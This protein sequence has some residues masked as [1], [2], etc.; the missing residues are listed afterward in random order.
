[1]A[2]KMRILR[3]ASDLHLELRS[4]LQHPKLLP[5][6]NFNLSKDD[7]YYLA[8]L[9]DIGNPYNDNLKKFLEKISPKYQKIFYIPGNHEYYNLNY[10]S[11]KSKKD[12]DREL[13]KICE[14]FGN[15]IIMNNKTCII[16]DDIKIIGSTLWSHVPENK[17]AH[18]SEVINDYHVIKKESENNLISITIDDTNKWNAESV[19]FIKK[20]IHNSK[21]LCI[22]LTHHAPLFSDEKLNRYTADP[23]Y[24]NGENNFAFHN[25]LMYLLKSPVV[26]WLYGHTHY[27]NSFNINGITIATNQLGYSAEESKIKFNSYAFINLDEIIFDNL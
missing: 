16:D 3:Y 13:E 20:E 11:K 9:G 14:N 10:E 17:S 6:W 22:I 2:H 24:L 1:M 15:I 5:L 25:D 7:E 4:T 18:I 26:A 21:H 19:E 8:L 27:T 23:T 12:F